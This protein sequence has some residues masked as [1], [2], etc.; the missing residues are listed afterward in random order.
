MAVKTAVDAVIL[1]IIGNIQRR[2]HLHRVAEVLARLSLRALRHLLE[3]GCRRGRKQRGEVLRSEHIL[4]QRTLDIGGGVAVR[5]V[6]VHTG[7]DLVLDLRA[8]VVHARL[9]SH[10]VGLGGDIFRGDDLLFCL[11]HKV[12]PSFVFVSDKMSGDIQCIGRAMRAPAGEWPASRPCGVAAVLLT[13]FPQPGGSRSGSLTLARAARPEG[14]EVIRKRGKTQFVPSCAPA[15][16]SGISPHT[17][18]SAPPRLAGAHQ[19]PCPP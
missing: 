2:K 9:V 5:V 8:D 15:A 3:E 1:A 12:I 4:V 16:R 18:G 17:W 19:G 13:L 7:D 10:V 6:S 11:I 14:K